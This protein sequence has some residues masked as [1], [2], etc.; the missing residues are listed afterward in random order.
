MRSR[1]LAGS[2]FFVS[3]FFVTFL[4]FFSSDFLIF[5]FVHLHTFHLFFAEA[6]V[7][8]IFGDYFLLP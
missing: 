1:A 3:L 8:N 6:F 4:H 7:L 5:T 2:D